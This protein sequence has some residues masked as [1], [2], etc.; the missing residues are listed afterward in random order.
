MCYNTTIMT[1]KDVLVHLRLPF[2]VFLLPIA[3]L[4]L[5][6]AG[7][8]NA[9]RTILIMLI[10]HLGVYTAS[11]AF[12]SYY[13]RDESPVGGIRKP[14]KVDKALLWTSLILEF[15]VVIVSLAVSWPFAV[16]VLVY[17]L[18]SKAYSWDRIRW[19]RKPIVS[20][21]G[22]ALVQGA[23]VFWMVALCAG[24]NAPLA[25]FGLAA[26]PA[27]VAQAVGDRMPELAFG[28]LVTVLFL[29][30][31]YP[32]TQVYQHQADA[33]RGD[34]T[35]SRLVGI[36]GT[37]AWAAACMGATAIAFAPYFWVTVSTRLWLPM[38]ILAATLLPAM[39]FFFSWWSKVRQDSQNANFDQT[40]RMN[41][42][43][44]AG[45]NVGLGLILAIG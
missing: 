28:A 15:A 43:A 10:I 24:T 1:L 37:F 5:H 45:L 25:G 39:I 26:R 42:L 29:L 35:F 30:A 16:G 23:L 17:G 33:Q 3:L 18:F 8:L 7:S 12:N 2:S 11:N 20:L 31:V 40:M 14:P 32:L 13:D 9:T 27:A 22:I 41:F 6:A 4:G 36:P 44:S 38:I 34:L 21:F 19:K